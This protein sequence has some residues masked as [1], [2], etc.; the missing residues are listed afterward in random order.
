[1]IEDLIDV[2]GPALN[3]QIEFLRKSSVPWAARML[4]AGTHSLQ[5]GSITS[6]VV[7]GDQVSIFGNLDKLHAKEEVGL[8]KF[9]V[10]QVRGVLLD[11]R[12]DD[13]ASRE[14]LKSIE[15]ALAENSM[16]P[17]ITLLE[18]DPT[19]VIDGNK[20]AAAFHHL[21][22]GRDKI[23]LKVFVVVKV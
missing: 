18:G 15:K 1:V 16:E 11:K 19:I 5:K 7:L 21:H 23:E 20:T 4:E 13:H 6:A 12:C 3:A 9:L 22:E 14:R 8:D 17:N 2:T 10:K